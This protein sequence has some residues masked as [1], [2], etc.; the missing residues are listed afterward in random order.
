MLMAD[1]TFDLIKSVILKCFEAPDHSVEVWINE[2]MKSLIEVNKE[3]NLHLSSEDEGIIYDAIGLYFCKKPW[4]S[5]NR[6][7]F[8]RELSKKSSFYNWRLL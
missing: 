7:S 2:N 3:D 8:L 4:P 6:S 1:N 5:Q